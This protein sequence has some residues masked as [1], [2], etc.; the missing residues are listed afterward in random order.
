[1]SER[2][3]SLKYEFVKRRLYDNYVER[4][5]KKFDKLLSNLA[6]LEGWISDCVNQLEVLEAK[7][8]GLEMHRDSNFVTLPG[9]KEAL[10]RQG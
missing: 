5:A 8:E 10:R 9:R 2:S 3:D 6:N 7:V 4:T 1:M